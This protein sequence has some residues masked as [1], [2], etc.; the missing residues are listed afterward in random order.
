MVV[1]G[2][3]E[4]L[5]GA[6]LVVLGLFMPGFIAV[7]EKDPS[8]DAAELAFMKDVLTWTY[9]A[10]G[11]GGVVGGLLRLAGGIQTM[12]FKSHVLGL[13]GNFGGLLS[14]TTCYCSIFSVG[15]SVYGLI[16]L[17]QPSVRD[18]FRR[19]A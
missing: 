12:R 17:F 1:M 2:A 9:A 14:L 18:E 8:M 19:R 13:V 15:V 6:G 5:M 3:L 16:V 10:M 7:I 11:G 4:L